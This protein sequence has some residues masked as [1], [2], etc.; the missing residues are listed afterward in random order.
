VEGVFIRE[1]SASRD[2]SEDAVMMA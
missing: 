2:G 1:G